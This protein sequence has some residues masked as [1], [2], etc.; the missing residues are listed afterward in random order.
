MAYRSFDKL[1]HHL[2][3]VGANLISRG[4]GNLR[5]Y[6]SRRTFFE[7]RSIYLPINLGTRVSNFLSLPEWINPPWKDEEP[8]S[9]TALQ[10]VL[11]ISFRVPPLMEG[12]E[13]I[14]G[15]PTTGFPLIG[16]AN[17][18]FI[19]GILQH[20]LEIQA[21]LERWDQRLRKERDDLP[22]I[23]IPRKARAFATS[24]MNDL[25]D[26]FPDSYSFPNWDI[27]SGLIYR[28]MIQIYLNTFLLEIMA[29]IL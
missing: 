26:V 29:Y 18:R 24:D 2:N 6:T 13:R 27:A 7:Y 8:H 10:T 21:D 28:E 14:R 12:F 9:R 15:F 22:D 17:I 19:D 1:L 23:Y 3:G 5:S 20:A 25:H 4:V 11:D 16:D